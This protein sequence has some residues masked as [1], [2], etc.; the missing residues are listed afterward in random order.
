MK[1]DEQQST[2]STAC[3][4]TRPGGI[5]R[6][7]WRIDYLRDPEDAATRNNTIAYYSNI[8]APNWNGGYDVDRYPSYGPDW[9]A[10]GRPAVDA[11]KRWAFTNSPQNRSCSRRLVRKLPGGRESWAD[12][13]VVMGADDQIPTKPCR[14][15]GSDYNLRF[16]ISRPRRHG[17]CPFCVLSVLCVNRAPPTE[18]L[19]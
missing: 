5:M 13:G 19:S 6:R 11:S 16:P 14:V 4:S 9:R 15:S 17:F 10:S 2:F 7:Q 1:E 12:P 8:Y 18:A 3:V